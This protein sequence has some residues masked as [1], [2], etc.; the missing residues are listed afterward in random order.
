MNILITGSTGFVGQNLIKS[1]YFL[2][3]NI[4]NFDVRKDSNFDKFNNI[5]IVIHMAGLAH[6]TKNIRNDEDYFKINT[7]YTKLIYDKYINSTATKFITLSSIKAVTDCSEIV[8]DELMIPRPKSEYG[9]SK[10]LAEKYIVNY[11]ISDIKKYYILRPSLIY[12]PNIKGNLNS[13]F[14]FIIKFQFWPFS[15][16]KNKRSY[17]YIENLFFVINELIHTNTIKSGIYNVS[18]KDPISTTDI[19]ILFS[20]I[21]HIKVLYLHLPKYLISLLVSFSKKIKLDFISDNFNKITE[22]NIV[23]NSLLTYNLNKDLPFTVRNGLE[24]TIKQYSKNRY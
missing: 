11:P 17:C 10:L 22:T 21:K 8:I 20:N 1:K 9:L 3:H 16:Y 18:D 24:E 6:D 7:D 13:L 5:D 15:N 14:Y 2:Q 23:D 19:V 4:I 12:G